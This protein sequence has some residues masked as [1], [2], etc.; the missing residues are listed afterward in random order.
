MYLK[1]DGSPDLKKLEKDLADGGF[2]CRYDTYMKVSDYN[3]LRRMLGLSEVQLKKH[4][5]IIHIKE[6]IR[7]EVES[8]TDDI[9]IEGEEG[10]LKFAGYYTVYR[11]LRFHPLRLIMQNWPLILRVKR[12]RVWERNWMDWQ[13][14]MTR[15][16]RKRQMKIL[17]GI[18]RWLE[19]SAADQIRLS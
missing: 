2:Y 8:M 5:Y 7:K 12:R 9:A 19:I 11:I 6:R 17:E 18:S 14:R 1:K 4:E 16:M 13:N 3:D 15:N 10:E